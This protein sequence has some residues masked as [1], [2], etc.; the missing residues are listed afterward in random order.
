MTKLQFYVC[1]SAGLLMT[2]PASAQSSETT[3]AR[4]A[5]P[6][7]IQ[8]GAK[9]SAQTA[10]AQLIGQWNVEL[11]IY[12]TLGRSPDLPP[13]VTRDIRASR[14]W[15]AD[16][17]YLEET[18]EGSVDGMPYWR[19]GWLGY[20]NMDRRYEWVTVAPLVPMMFYQGKAGSGEKMP[21]E[22]TGS[23]TDQGVVSERTVGQTIGQRTVI[24]VDGPDRQ[25]SELYFK[26]PN[27]KEQLAM[28]MVFTRA[29]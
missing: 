26:L 10:M 14:R 27:G 29:K 12:G 8:R 20:S 5:V 13:I 22:V 3:A 2:V 16:G 6:A 7:W 25:V 4:P 28:R 9:G 24:R 23:F 1:L 11:S 19:R 18:I 15:I 17:Q 21:I